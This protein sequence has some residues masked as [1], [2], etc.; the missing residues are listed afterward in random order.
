MLFSSVGFICGDIKRLDLS[1]EKQEGGGGGGNKEFKDKCKAKSIIRSIK[2]KPW[3]LQKGLAKKFKSSQVLVGKVLK[4]QEYKAN[5]KKKLQSDPL[6]EKLKQFIVQISYIN[7]L[8]NKT[9]YN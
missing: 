7:V 9:C 2:E 3:Q 8:A 4:S 6:M 5:H 1:T